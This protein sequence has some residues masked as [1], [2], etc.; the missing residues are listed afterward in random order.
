[1]KKLLFPLIFSLSLPVLAANQNEAVLKS[2]TKSEGIEIAKTL[3]SNVNNLSQY[4]NAH[5]YFRAYP[6]YRKDNYNC[7]DVIITKHSNYG[8]MTACNIS[9]DWVFIYE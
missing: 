5:T 4:K 2:L 1:M 8:D 6:F 3:N 7:R 9:G